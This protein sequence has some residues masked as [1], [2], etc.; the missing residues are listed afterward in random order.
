VPEPDIELIPLT[1][2]GD[3]RGASFPLGSAWLDFLGKAV[4]C[5]ISTIK[6]GQ[7]R[8]NHYHERKREIIVV[9]HRDRWTM[10]W[11][12]GANTSPQRQEFT[13]GG[14]VMI[15]TSPGASHAV[16]NNGSED[17]QLFALCNQLYDPAH[18]DAI[19]RIVSAL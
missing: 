9:V 12:T 18:P 5:H 15:K 7:T 19:A 17:L 10:C 3:Q 13:G 11:D 1:D 2:S 8:G 16:V 6:P 14:A 4:D